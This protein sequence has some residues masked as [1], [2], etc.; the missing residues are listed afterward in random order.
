MSDQPVK[1]S[2]EVIKEMGERDMTFTEEQVWEAV[3]AQVDA[4]AVPWKGEAVATGVLFRLTRPSIGPAV[5]VTYDSTCGGRQTTHADFAGNV[6][7]GDFNI[8]PHYPEDKVLRWLRETLD[9]A[10]CLGS[11]R[12]DAEDAMRCRMDAH[13]RG[14]P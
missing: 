9:E 4:G 3:R 12:I 6:D 13:K 2:H 5:V 11:E 7:P 8:Q 10:T 1:R 14:T